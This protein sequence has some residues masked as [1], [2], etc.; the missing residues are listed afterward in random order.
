MYNKTIK[1]NYT[2]KKYFIDKRR[3]WDRKTYM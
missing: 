2:K 1:K 3:W